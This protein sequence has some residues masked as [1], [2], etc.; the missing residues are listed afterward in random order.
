MAITDEVGATVYGGLLGWDASPD[1]GSLLLSDAAAHELGF[2]RTVRIVFPAESNSS[3]QL[4]ACLG[5][6]VE[7]LGRAIPQAFVETEDPA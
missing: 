3:Q 2:T 7:P 5:W 1:E 6:I 4:V